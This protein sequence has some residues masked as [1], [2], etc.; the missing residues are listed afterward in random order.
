MKE[1]DL[2]FLISLPRS[3]ST[4]LQRLLWEHD[5]IHTT[6]EPYI[7]FWPLLALSPKMQTVTDYALP[8]AQRQLNAFLETTEM[9][10]SGYKAMVRDNLLKMYSSSLSHTS[11]RC[12]LDKSPKYH[13]ILPELVEMFPNAKYIIL[14]RH[15]MGV[16]G[17]LV[18]WSKYRWKDLRKSRDDLLEGPDHLINFISDRSID[19]CVLRYED[20]L[21]EPESGLKQICDYLDLKFD[22]SMKEYDPSVTPPGHWNISGGTGMFSEINPSRAEGWRTYFSDRAKR[23][24]ALDYLYCLGEEKYKALGYD[25]NETET[26]LKSQNM[27]FTIPPVM[28]WKTL[29]LPQ[30]LTLRQ[31]LHIRFASLLSGFEYLQERLYRRI[32]K[33]VKN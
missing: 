5:K 23:K 29:M 4:L 26:M 2:I 24:I 10:A 32:T 14:K 11:A 22:A 9:G 28:G 6:G 7:A 3:G 25:Y 16:L 17:S 20:L 19:K 15:P 27:G 31:R 13:N 8:H 21:T 30:K 18:K 1:T 12:F 33:K